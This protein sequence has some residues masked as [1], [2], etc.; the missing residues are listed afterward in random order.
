[1]LNVES[2]FVVV[3]LQGRDV[4]TV[5][6]VEVRG[7]VD[8]FNVVAAL[9]KNFKLTSDAPEVF[10]RV[11]GI[12]VSPINHHVITVF[13]G[14]G[15]SP[16][17]RADRAVRTL[18][19]AFDP[20]AVIA[21]GATGVRGNVVF[22]GSLI[23]ESK[24][25]LGKITYNV[26][27]YL[28]KEA[29]A[30]LLAAVLVG[31]CEAT[32]ETMA[33]IFFL[34][35][36]TQVTQGEMDEME[37]TECIKQH[38]ALKS[39][40]RDKHRHSILPPEKM[41]RIAKRAPRRHS[42]VI[43]DMVQGIP[44]SNPSTKARIMDAA[45]AKTNTVPLKH[46]EEIAEMI[47]PLLTPN[48]EEHTDIMAI[49]GITQPWSALHDSSFGRIWKGISKEQMIALYNLRIKATYYDKFFDPAADGPE[50]WDVQLA[51]Q[52]ANAQL[53]I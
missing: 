44:C 41:A 22:M 39:V 43:E 23:E 16:N 38:E 1:M 42:S 7:E 35:N 52:F 51:R 32:H 47:Q 4:P 17:A 33:R 28:L 34:H 30:H 2:G 19:K 31:E 27:P 20:V 5:A 29:S 37:V 18:F 36:S 48:K 6:A 13:H 24:N 49:M 8:I 26:E 25:S 50:V 46:M 45:R 3:W 53:P 21:N 40:A 14:G 11:R 12:S 9:K 15:P 10:S